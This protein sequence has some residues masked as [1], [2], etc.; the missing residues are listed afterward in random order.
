MT[1]HN[2]PDSALQQGQPGLFSLAQGDPLGQALCAFALRYRF[3]AV[4]LA[5]CSSLTAAIVAALEGTL[6]NPSL[7]LDLLSD[8][9][10]WNQFAL[11]L[12]AL[13]YIA[14]AY[15]GEFPRTL[16]S[17]VDDGVLLASDEQWKAVRA[18]ASNT[19]GQT[20]F[21]LAPFLCGLAA[22]AASSTVI[23]TPGAWFSVDEYG[24][25]WLVPVHSFFLYF[26][27]AYLALRLYAAYRILDRLF[28]YGVN[29]QPFHQDGSGGL[30]S[31][32][33][34]SES[35]YFG[36][37]VFGFVMAL[38]VISNTVVYGQSL[39]SAFNLLMYLGFVALTAFAFFLP[40]YALSSYMQEA[41]EK[42]LKTIGERM[43]AMRKTAAEGQ[44]TSGADL[45][46][47]RAL[48]RTARSMQVWPFDAMSLIRFAAVAVSPLPV[49]F[50][51]LQFISS[52]AGQL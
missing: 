2:K 13:A 1:N 7:Q 50:I 46:A 48:R 11:A 16:R 23:Q 52:Q 49:I 30:G 24:A 33:R 8:I 27:M 21:M 39:L 5:S 37:L 44:T 19:L 15:F 22:A 10:W 12:P 29:I 35:L 42:L 20:P 14:S 4:V 3:L 40:T 45:G 31:L 38:G 47:L 9:G 34:L 43:A 41:K 36:M 17:L 51:A 28:D 18:F 32:R 26:S 25:G 6:I